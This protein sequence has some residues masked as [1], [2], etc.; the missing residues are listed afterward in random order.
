MSLLALLK[1][2]NVIFHGLVMAT[3]VVISGAH[4]CMTPSL[5][6]NSL[7]VGVVVFLFTMMWDKHKYNT[8]VECLA[9]I[10]FL[11]PHGGCQ[12]YSLKVYICDNPEWISVVRGYKIVRILKASSREVRSYHIRVFLCVIGCRSI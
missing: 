4:I 2:K 11:G 3:C 9:Q 7:L 1:I 8:L 10:N 5:P 12:L 6:S